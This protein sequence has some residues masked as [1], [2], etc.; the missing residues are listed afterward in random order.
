MNLL[1]KVCYVNACET[2]KEDGLI[3]LEELLYDLSIKGY[4]HVQRGNK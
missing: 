2:G 3:L 1:N 4:W